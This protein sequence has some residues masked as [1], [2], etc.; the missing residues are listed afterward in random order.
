MKKNQNLSKEEGLEALLSVNVEANPS[1]TI[2]WIKDEQDI[3]LD[4]RISQLENGSLLISA[5]SLDDT[6]NW[7]ISAE[8]GLGSVTRHIV[9]SVHPSRVPIEVS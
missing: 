6:G 2:S 8:N 3:V 4:D 7:T 9:L 5:A 1:P